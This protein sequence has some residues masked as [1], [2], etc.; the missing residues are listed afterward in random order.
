MQILF[1]SPI[2]YLSDFFSVGEEH[3]KM[4]VAFICFIQHLGKTPLLVKVKQ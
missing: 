4:G 2:D 3:W 1:K